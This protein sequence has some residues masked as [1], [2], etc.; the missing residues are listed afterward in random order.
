MHKT[1]REALRLVDALVERRSEFAGVDVVIAPPFTALEAVSH[2][3]RGQDAIQLAAQTMHWEDSGPF[4]GEISPV[5]LRELGVQYVILGHSERRAFCG[6][7]DA[8]I[9]RKVAAALKHGLK[10]IVAVGETLEEKTAGKTAEKV[11][12]QTRAAL[13]GLNADEIRRAVLAYEPIWA[14][15]T[16]KN[17]DPRNAGATMGI[18]RS[19]V[20]GLADVPVLYGGSVKPDNMAGYAAMEEINGALVGGASLDA[21]SFAAI[22]AASAGA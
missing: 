19:S 13:D 16:G 6:E 2:R 10:P 7:T 8:F 5:M 9:Q 4:T 3:L 20:P 21:D 1:V 12:R 11:T 17:D 18:I 14:I 15:G 22:V